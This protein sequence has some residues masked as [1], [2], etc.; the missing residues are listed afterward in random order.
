MA[1]TKSSASSKSESMIPVTVVITRSDLSVKF[2]ANMKFSSMPIVKRCAEDAADIVQS[3]MRRVAKG[4]FDS[5]DAIA[6]DMGRFRS[7]CRHR[8]YDE[9]NLCVDLV[10]EFITRIGYTVQACGFE[11]DNGKVTDPDT[12]YIIMTK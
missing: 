3:L 4:D 2:T 8:G 10:E 5:G 6:F 12:L 9:E 7:I 1:S 11:N